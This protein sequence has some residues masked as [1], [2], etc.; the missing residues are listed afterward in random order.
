MWCNV[1]TIKYSH[2]F[3]A[4]LFILY[5]PFYLFLAILFILYTPFYLIFHPRPHSLQDLSSPT[6]DWSH[7]LA[8]KVWGPNHWTTREFSVL[9]FY[10]YM[11]MSSD[12]WI[13]LLTSCVLHKETA[14]SSCIAN[15]H[16]HLRGPEPLNTAP[17]ADGHAVYP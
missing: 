1:H 8:V 3:L 17:L 5:T 12:K 14:I 2:F 10:W 15:S 4:I 16:A 9:P 11:S 7:T 6:R 13:C